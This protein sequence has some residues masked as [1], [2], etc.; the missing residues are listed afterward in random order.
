MI[1]KNKLQIQ[2]IEKEI[3]LTENFDNLKVVIELEDNF[4]NKIIKFYNFEDLKNYYLNKIK[5][6]E[7]EI[8]YTNK[9]KNNLSNYSQ[10]N[11]NDEII[12][13]R[14]IEY[15]YINLFTI[16]FIF[17]INSIG[18]YFLIFVLNSKRKN[19]N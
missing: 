7:N 12:S 17:I 2:K 11:I 18:I 14:F 6:L 19:K 4:L 10:I 13:I 15:N 3:K 5:L 16:V 1:N 8:E 9:I